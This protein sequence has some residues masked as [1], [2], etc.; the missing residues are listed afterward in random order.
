MSHENVFDQ[1]IMILP[2]IAHRRNIKQCNTKKIKTLH[3][4]FYILL[5]SQ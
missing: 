5:L 2:D 3:I 4:T 1:V